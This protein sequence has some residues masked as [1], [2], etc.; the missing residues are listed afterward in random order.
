MRSV[1]KMIRRGEKQKR[2]VSFSVSTCTLENLRITAGFFS[3]NHAQEH[4][5]LKP[6]DLSLSSASFR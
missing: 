6:G 3:R 1:R 4:C 2:Q 5:Q